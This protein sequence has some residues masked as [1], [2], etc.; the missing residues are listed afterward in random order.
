MYTFHRAV[1]GL[2]EV[3]H[4]KF[5]ELWLA[6][7]KHTINACCYSFPSGAGKDLQLNGNIIN[8]QHPPAPRAP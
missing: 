8:Y 5:V 7:S 1:E 6:H 4:V 3:I 2:N